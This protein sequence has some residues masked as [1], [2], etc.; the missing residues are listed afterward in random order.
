MVLLICKC[1]RFYRYYWNYYYRDIISI[2]TAS[3]ALQSIVSLHTGP[4]LAA[5]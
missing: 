2:L 4:L 3:T 1:H 5:Y